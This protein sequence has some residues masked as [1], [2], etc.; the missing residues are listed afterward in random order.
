MR[1]NQGVKTVYRVTPPRVVAYSVQPPR[2][3]GYDLAQHETQIEGKHGGGEEERHGARQALGYD[4]GHA[5]GV[6]AKG[7][8]KAAGEDILD[9][10]EELLPQR[11]VEPE[12]GLQPFP[13]IRRQFWIHRIHVANV[14]RLRIDE[15]EDDADE[16]EQ[17]Q[18]YLNRPA[19]KIGSHPRSPPIAIDY[20]ASLFTLA[21]LA[22]NCSA[23]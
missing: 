14:A 6:V 4:V 19:K 3:P 23:E 11:L 9:V 7:N 17:S 15:E 10:D 8:A 21:A 18:Q 2:F 13:G 1:A 5:A 22:S 20:C 12:L 16:C